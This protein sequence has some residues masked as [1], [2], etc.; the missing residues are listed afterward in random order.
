MDSKTLIDGVLAKAAADAVASITPEQR[1]ELMKEAVE[2]QIAGHLQGY[3]FRAEIDKIIGPVQ[4]AALQEYVDEPEVRERI[5]QRA[6]MAGEKFIDGLIDA[7][8]NSMA[9]AW[10]VGEQYPKA[11]AINALCTALGVEKKR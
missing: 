8:L 10:G 3:G 4:L 5:R 7:T 6:R 11:N 9:S 2:K 1:R